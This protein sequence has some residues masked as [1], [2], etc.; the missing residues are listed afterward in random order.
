[1]S[2][3]AWFHLGLR[4]LPNCLFTLGA[5]LY[6]YKCG[7]RGGDR[8][9]RPPP[10]KSQVIW[11]SIGN[12]QLEKVGAPLENVGPPLKPW[13][14]IDFF[15]IDHLTSVKISWGLKKKKINV[16]RAFFVRLTWTPLTK[17][18]GSV[19]DIGLF[20]IIHVLQN[21]L[22]RFWVFRMPNINCCFYMVCSVSHRWTLSGRERRS[23]LWAMLIYL[24]PWQPRVDWLHL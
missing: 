1:M 10:G 13:K 9:S 22:Q 14:M 3:L 6:T 12:K 20:L 7:S 11:V 5:S 19:H 23:M 24:L 4:C 18:P 21:V 17:F 16:V 2:H 8:G 15:K